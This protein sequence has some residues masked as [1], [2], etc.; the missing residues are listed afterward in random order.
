MTI[1]QL[2]EKRAAKVRELRQILDA[3]SG[4]PM[5]PE[6]DAA[7]KT[8]ETECRAINDQIARQ[9]RL[10]QMELAAAATPLNGTPDFD[11]ACRAPGLFL[12][13]IAASAGIE[14]RDTARVREI[15]QELQRR[16][17]RKAQGIMIPTEIFQRPRHEQRV[18]VSGTTGAGAI[19]TDHRGDLTID[20][21]RAASVVD[22]L[23]ATVL[24]NLHGNVSIPAVD[25]GF[26][27]AWI[28]ENG[29]L[30]P[31][32]WDINA[33][34]LTP[35]HVGALTEFSRNMIL[36]ADPSVD[37]M[38]MRDGARALAAA[39]DAA[40]LVGGG[41]NQPSGIG[42][43][44]TPTTF[45]TP[46]WAEG[47]A[48]IASI[49]NTNALMGSLGWAGHPDVTKKLRSTLVAASTDSRMIMSEPN[50]LYGYQYYD[51]TAL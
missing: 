44:V 1:P 37:Q 4:A 22:R 43:T 42:A 29:A 33:R 9:E 47:L 26:T 39:L 28:A 46:T 20:M 48:M 32:D 41:A 35:K 24:S 13:A 34:T 23:G 3:A 40:A 6:Q 36:Q 2:Q 8:L 11:R 27:A 38:A 25:T 31:A 19:G 49:A 30:S 51:T 12:D 50:S 17:G 16:T 10:N 45:A 15:S 5:T 18:V 21:L 14:G 7:Y